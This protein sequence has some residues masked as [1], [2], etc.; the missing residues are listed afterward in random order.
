M[1][2]CAVASRIFV[3]CKKMQMRRHYTL[4]SFAGPLGQGI[5]NAVGIA[6][7]EAHLASR[8]NKP[9]MDPLMDH[10]T[11]ACSIKHFIE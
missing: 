1:F 6:A 2:T 7:A 4:H 8:F 11:Y 5:C 10:Y 9:D 3:G